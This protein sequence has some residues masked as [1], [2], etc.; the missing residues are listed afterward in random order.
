M[1]MWVVERRLEWDTGWGGSGEDSAL[2]AIDDSG[3]S[4]RL[5][6]RGVS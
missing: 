4:K 6:E 2:V 5:I 3:P 1:T